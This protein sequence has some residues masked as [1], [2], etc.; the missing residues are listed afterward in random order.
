MARGSR[1]LP[2]SFYEGMSTDREGLSRIA[3][4]SLMKMMSVDDIQRITFSLYERPG[5]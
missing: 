4:A 1:D 2:Q 3:P 5:P